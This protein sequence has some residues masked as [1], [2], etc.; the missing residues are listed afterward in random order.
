MKI[1]YNPKCSKSREAKKKLDE[2]GVAYTIHL[3]LDTPLSYAEIEVILVKLNLNVRD[4]I[5]TKESIWQDNFKGG[6]FSDQELVK[7]V[8]DNPILLERPII[9]HKNIAVV[10]RSEEKIVEI[11]ATL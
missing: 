3:Y 6:T 9:E 7:I 2:R 1:Y 10:A 8:A 5:R 11:L 4:I